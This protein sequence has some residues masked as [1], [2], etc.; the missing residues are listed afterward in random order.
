MNL[1]PKIFGIWTY[2]GTYAK[3]ELFTAYNSKYAENY[4]YYYY[5]LSPLCRVFTLTFLKV[6][7]PKEYSAAGIL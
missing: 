4:Y 3:S 1:H 7:V 6:H 5:Y 2:T